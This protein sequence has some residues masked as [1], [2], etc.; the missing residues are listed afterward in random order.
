MYFIKFGS[1]LRFAKYLLLAICFSP[2]GLRAEKIKKTT[3]TIKAVGDIVPGTN[4][5][6]NR[7][8]SDPYTKLF[9]KVQKYL[10][11]ADILFGN[12][13]STLTD[14]PKSSKDTSRKMVFAFRNPPAYAQIFKKAGFDVMSTANNHSGD[15]GTK[16]FNDTMRHLEKAGVRAVGKKNQIVY[17]EARGLKVAF[18]AFS[19]LGSHNNIKKM[20]E[21]KELITKAANNSDIT[22][23][24][25]HWGAE[26]PKHLHTKNQTEMFYGENRGN[27]VAFSHM[28]ID[29][30]ADLILGHGPHVPRAVELYKKKLVAYSLGNFIGYGALSSRGVTGHSLVL[31]VDL[32]ADGKFV[33]GEII[34]MHMPESSIPVYDENKKSIKLI[35]K[36][37]RIDFP[38]SLLR[39]S[40]EGKLSIDTGEPATE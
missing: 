4:F 40:D 5:P 16:G 24:S 33:K 36:L 34:P 8:P 2:L 25:C 10:S 6:N 38:K 13:E 31:Q 15:F 29:A 32:A 27:L 17:A 30:G 3:L 37:S 1:M 26:G 35:K 9:S 23:I 39:I 14:N 11:G 28:A 19:Y 21:A 7:L 18:V 12:F 22:V 20:A